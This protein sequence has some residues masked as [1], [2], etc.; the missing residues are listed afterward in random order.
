MLSEWARVNSK[1]Y[2]MFTV[3]ISE[4]L[5]SASSRL[6][7]LLTGADFHAGA[8]CKLLLADIFAL[9]SS[10]WSVNCSDQLAD[11]LGQALVPT[12]VQSRYFFSCFKGRTG[13]IPLPLEPGW[14]SST[15]KTGLHALLR[16][17]WISYFWVHMFLE[18][19]ISHLPSSYKHLLLS[20]NSCG[21]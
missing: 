9:C 5:Y 13:G 11:H 10:D 6:C 14:S 12:K 16:S 7:Y 2:V 8:V 1:H 19:E 20:Y 21:G 4:Y 17:K 3:V 18:L 15:D